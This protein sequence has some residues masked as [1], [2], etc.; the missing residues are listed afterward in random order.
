MV[1]IKRKRWGRERWEDKKVVV[2]VVVTLLPF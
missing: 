1:P 2:V